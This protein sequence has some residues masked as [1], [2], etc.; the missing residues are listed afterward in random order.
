MWQA[1]GK[2][3]TTGLDSPDR[4]APDRCDSACVV[5]GLHY[6][7]IMSE[8]MNANQI[9]TAIASI[10]ASGKKL[11]ADIQSAGMSI[12]NHADEHGDS[13]LADKLIEAMPKGS[14]KLALVEWMLAYG[15][16]RLLKKADIEDAVRIAAGAVFAFDKSKRTDLEA[17]AAKQWYTFKPEAP[18][19]T[20]FDAQAAVVK[21]LAGLTK[22]TTNG[23][24]I[25][26]RAHALAAAQKLVAALSD[27]GDDS[28]T[29]ED[30]GLSE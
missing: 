25:N 8:F 4:S 15:K 20:A 5:A 3:R 21:V 12:L 26:N 17:A 24:T 2:H 1:F 13:T 18:V 29:G 11:D 30:F 6:G 9:K 23:L 10:A 7:V 28:P 19:A 22:A 16:L 27:I 14:R